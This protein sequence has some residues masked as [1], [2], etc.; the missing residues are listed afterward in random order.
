MDIEI[1]PIESDQYAAFITATT[2]AFGDH[3]GDELIERFVSR[4]T[5]GRWIGAFQGSEIVGGVASESGEIG[6]EGGSLPVATVVAVTVQPTHTRRGILTR[7]KDY[8][9]RELHERGEPIAALWSSESPIYGRFG[10]GLASLD[11]Q[12]RIERPRAGFSLKTESTGSVRFV[13]PGEAAALFPD[14]YRRAVI[15]RP[16]AIELPKMKWDWMLADRES[17]RGGGGAF[18][19]VVYESNGSADGYASYRRAGAT[20]RVVELMSVSD[21]AHRALW[22][23]ILGVDLIDVVEVGRRALDDPLPWMLDDARALQREPQ[24]ALWVRLVDVGRALAERRYMR[25][26]RLVL[27][28][29]DRFCPWNEGTYELDAGPEGGQVRRSTAAPDL[30]ISAA[31]LASIYMGAVRVPTLVQ[32]GRIEERTPGSAKQ[33]AAMF[34]TRLAPWCPYYY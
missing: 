1:R 7:L 20:L 16:A 14:V 32:T 21:D 15:G 25:D 22:S 17:E 9:M 12:W 18:F 29:R 19:H 31:D 33:A 23:Y 27:E 26:G 6:V 30:V 8:Q 2:R 4:A 3:A 28:V 13:G 5:S 11:E 10:Y 34:A 24:E